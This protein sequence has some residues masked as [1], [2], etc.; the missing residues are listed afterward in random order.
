[1][2]GCFLSILLQVKI[3]GGYWVAFQQEKSNSV[4]YPLV[5]KT[6]DYY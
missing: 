5:Q 1:M 4:I 3:P 6:I 2:E